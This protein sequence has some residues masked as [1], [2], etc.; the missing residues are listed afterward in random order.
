MDVVKGVEGVILL[1]KCM[2]TLPKI[3]KH[4]KIKRGVKLCFKP[5]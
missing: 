5:K 3:N 1:A 2:I 4:V